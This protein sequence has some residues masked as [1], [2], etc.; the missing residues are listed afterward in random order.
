[1]KQKFRSREDNRSSRHRRPK[2]DIQTE[3]MDRDGDRRHRMKPMARTK[4]RDE[5]WDDQEE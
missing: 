3:K 1:M 2:K 5:Y 4:Y